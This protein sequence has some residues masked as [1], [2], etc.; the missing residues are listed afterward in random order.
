MTTVGHLAL[1]DCQLLQTPRRAPSLLSR[2]S[3]TMRVW[4]QRVRERQSLAEFSE[5]ELHDFG[6]SSADRFQ[7]LAKPF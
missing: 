1:T 6:A 2:L 7:E 4:R 3:R 5:H